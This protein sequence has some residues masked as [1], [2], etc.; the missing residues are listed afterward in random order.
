[1]SADNYLY[2]DLKKLKLWECV[3]SQIGD[4]IEQQKINLIGKFTTLEDA[5]AE[6]EQHWTEY[7]LWMELWWK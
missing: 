7:G 3:A 4:N 1:M 5:L 6:A 2:L